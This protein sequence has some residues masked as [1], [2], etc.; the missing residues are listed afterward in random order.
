MREIVLDTE[1]TGLDPFSGDRIVEIACVE[2]INC[3]PTGSFFH[4]YVNPERDV[5]E[6]ATQV[7]GLTLDFLKDFP[8]FESVYEKFLSFVK[9]DPLVIHNATFDL[10]FL[11]YELK[12]K[13][14]AP[15]SNPSVDTLRIARS[16]F[17]GSPASLDALCRRFKID[18]SSRTQHG[19]LVDCELLS[20][21]YLELCGG[22]QRGIFGS[23][24]QEK[25]A[26]GGAAL[27]HQDLLKHYQSRPAQEPRSFSVSDAEKKNHA[28]FLKSKF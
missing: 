26:E 15:L 7:H 20:G 8:V 19:A 5:P 21:V 3:I 2:L 27:S 4:T 24:S 6:R 12:Q 16:K 11:N 10:K 1:T 22:R 18:L 13:S 14:Q 25:D 17:P 28:D 23:Q 9:N